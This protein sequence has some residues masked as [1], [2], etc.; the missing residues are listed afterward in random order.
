VLRERLRH[1][2]LWDVY[3]AVRA[4]GLRELGWHRS[5]RERAPVDKQGSPL[6]WY[7]Y[8]AIRFLECRADPGWSV[9][10]YGCGNSTRWW[11]ER[12][13]RVRAVEHQSE[14]FHRVRAGLPEN[15]TV[16]L[17]SLD[18]YLHE[19]SRYQELYDVVVIDGRRR[20]RCAQAC[21]GALSPDGVIIWDNSDR[22]RYREGMDFLARHGFRQIEFTGLGPV[23][24][25][26]WSTAIFYRRWNCLSI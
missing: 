20:N 16:S 7:T 8:S 5:L 12:V 22:P 13:R 15:A 4:R 2:R 23:S 21:L 14:W 18:A 19:V 24:D 9:F 17:R 26:V 10:E 11:S 25:L 6:P 1:T 3:I